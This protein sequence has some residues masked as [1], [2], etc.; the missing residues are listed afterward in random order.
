MRDAYLLIVGLLH[1]ETFALVADVV[2]GVQVLH[3]LRPVTRSITVV[4][5]AACLALVLSGDG[6]GLDA[7]A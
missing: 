1:P 7:V 3:V 4:L 2:A 5:G 6:L